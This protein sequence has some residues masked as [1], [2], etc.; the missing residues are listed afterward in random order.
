MFV[1]AV[2]GVAAYMA[3]VG[4][5]QA[6]LIAGVAGF[7]VAVVGLA[8]ALS[9]RRSAA[10]GERGHSIQDMTDIVVGGDAAQIACISPVEDVSQNMA[11]VTARNG[12]ARQ[13]IWVFGRPH[14]RDARRRGGRDA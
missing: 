11:R 5:S 12:H 6:N 13:V 10:R 2:A 1:A 3:S 7:F 14:A 9:E 4:W 8:L